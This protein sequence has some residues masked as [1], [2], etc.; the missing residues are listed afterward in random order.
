MIVAG[1]DD[2]LEAFAKPEGAEDGRFSWVEEKGDRGAKKTI[3]VGTLYGNKKNTFTE[4][5]GTVKWQ[6]SLAVD[7]W[8]GATA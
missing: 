4:E 6:N 2:L 7:V 3:T 8:V 1:A 5:D